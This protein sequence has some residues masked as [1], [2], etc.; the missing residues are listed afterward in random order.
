MM[1]TIH[2]GSNFVYLDE[3]KQRHLDGCQIEIRW[4]WKRFKRKKAIKLAKKKEA[5]EKKKAGKY[6]KRGKTIKR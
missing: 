3:M 1:K 4:A 2:L 5:E 6:G